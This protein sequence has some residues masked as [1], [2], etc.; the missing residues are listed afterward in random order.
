[1]PTF[2]FLV[3]V[4][5]TSSGITGLCGCNYV[6][7]SQE[8][9]ILDIGWSSQ[10]KEEKGLTHRQNQGRRSRYNGGRDGRDAAGSQVISGASRAGRGRRDSPRELLG[11]YCPTH[12]WISYFWSSELWQ[13]T[14]LLLETFKLVQ[15]PQETNIHPIASS[16]LILSI[17]QIYGNC[18]SLVKLG[19]VCKHTW[20]PWSTKIIIIDERKRMGF[21]VQAW[22]PVTGCIL[23]TVRNAVPW[24]QRMD[25]RVAAWAAAMRLDGQWGQVSRVDV[26]DLSVE[27]EADSKDKQLN[28]DGASKSCYNAII[29]NVFI[30]IPLAFVIL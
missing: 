9:I 27:V 12:T 20:N 28:T 8:E 18:H 2:S 24:C 23:H 29:T 16:Y 14:F 22:H 30:S 15:Q 5:V 11:E 13:N 6:K 3:P 21:G 26:Q 19:D 7:R 4:D 10:E 1:M 25:A 17:F